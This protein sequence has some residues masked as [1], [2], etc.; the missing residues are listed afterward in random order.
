M[1][2]YTPSRTALRVAMRRA[3]HQIVDHPKVFDDPLALAI[4]G[5]HEASNLSRDP[6]AEL[7]LRAFIVVR[8]RFAEDELGAAVASGIK[9]YVVLGAGLDTF[10]FRNPYA[11]AGLR[12]FEVDHPQTQ[13]WKREHLRTAGIAIPQDVTF[14]AVDFERQSIADGLRAAGLRMDEPAWF[15]W[16]GVVPYLTQTAFHNTLGFIASLPPSS[17]VV[18]DYAIERALLTTH[19]Q[20]MFDA[21][22]ARVARAG[23]PFQLFFKPAELA[24]QLTSLG[25]QRIQ[26]L[27]VRELNARYF[28]DAA[29]EFRIRG[30]LGRLCSSQISTTCK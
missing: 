23:E 10:A 5:S 19:Q 3:Q 4:I 29:S 17:G 28:P 27:G 7:S 14:A 11:A 1:R 22:A 9:Q 21:L 16:L 30:G 24:E 2:D 20:E 26:D 25:F 15:S 12:V 18:F 8:S 6:A 13:Q